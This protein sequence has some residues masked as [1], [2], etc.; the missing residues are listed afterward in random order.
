[1]ES[2]VTEHLKIIQI[3]SQNQILLQLSFSALGLDAG[4][5]KREA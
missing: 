4:Q 1:M 2:P 5:E 3:R